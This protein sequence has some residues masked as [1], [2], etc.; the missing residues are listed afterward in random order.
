[1][2]LSIKDRVLLP[3]IFKANQDSMTEAS[4]QR[5]I[6]QLVAISEAEAKEMELQQTPDGRVIWN[7]LK[8]DDKEMSFDG[9]QLHYLRESVYNLSKSRGVT[10]DLLPLCEKI[11]GVAL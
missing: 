4:V 11:Q 10:Q 1:M 9:T 5:G 2:I 3:G 6:R 7:A 8:A